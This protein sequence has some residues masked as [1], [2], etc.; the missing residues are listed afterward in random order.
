MK[1]RS[2]LDAA[3]GTFAATAAGIGVPAFAQNAVRQI[4]LGFTSRS[5]TDWGLYCASHAGFYTANNLK[6]DEIVI[7]SSA[8]CAQQLTA[9]SIDIGSV[10]S[11]QIIQAVMGGAPIVEVL[12]EVITPPYFVLAK[13]GIANIAALRGKTVILGGPSDITR[14]FM[15]KVIAG[16]NLKADDVTYTYAGASSDR[17]AAL[18]SGG[19]DAAMLL[20]PFSFRATDD[21]FVTIAEVQKYIPHFP[22]GGLAARTAWAKSNPE[23]VAAFD[24]SYVQGIRWLYNPANKARAIAILVE[25]TNSKPDD[26]SRTYDAYVSHLQL[27]SKDGRFAS[28]DFALVIDTLLKTDQIK[29]PAPAPA[30]L[31]DNHYADVANSQLRR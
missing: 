3:A 15:D 8:G 18:V 23:T 14:V 11:T 5:S 22:F 1:R 28:A 10:S 17:Y 20:P 2:F 19:V 16:N 4:T 31:Y 13:K 9:G 30:T 21:G 7:G 25:V 12:N 26:A 27:F 29:A 6:V 24:K